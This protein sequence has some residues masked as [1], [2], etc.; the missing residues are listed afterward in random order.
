MLQRLDRLQEDAL[1]ALAAAEDENGLR[2][3]EVQ[4][5]GKRGALTALLK[6]LGKLP[7]EERPAVGQAANRVKV[8]LA[9]ELLNRRKVLAEAQLAA[10][11]SGEGFDSTLPGPGA[12]DGSLHPLTVLR[13]ELEDVFLSMGFRVVDGPELETEAHNFDDLNIP[14][15]H[16]ARESHDT[17]WVRNPSQPGAGD[18][19]CMRTHTSPVQI[20][21]LRRFGAPLK[22]VAPGRVFRQETPD[23]SHDH[24]FHQMEGLV[25]GPGVGVSHMLHAMRSL[26]AGAFGK[27]LET[28][29]RPGFFPF[30]EPGFELDARCPFCQSG[31]RVCKGSTW[32]ELMPGGLVH[33]EV[34]RAGGV[35]PQEHSGYAFGLGLSR[36][37]MLRWG[38]DNVRWLLSGDLRFLGQ[39]RS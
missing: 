35:D 12:P 21:A 34:L 33:P 30:V 27:E 29:L 3:L 14:G 10:E 2:Q 19:L 37:A 22:V 38:I 15:D 9:A 6:G 18:G 36:L 39:F 25:V 23:A 11:L 32:I 24:T 1:A 17:L 31:C 13:Q 26:L 8:T 16:P 20:R 7:A 5:L 28:R 4:F